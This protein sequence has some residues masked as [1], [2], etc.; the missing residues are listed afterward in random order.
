MFDVDGDLAVEVR[1]VVVIVPHAFS[2]MSPLALGVTFPLPV[3]QL[4]F[5]PTPQALA[6]MWPPVPTA[7]ASTEAVSSVFAPADSRSIVPPSEPPPVAVAWKARLVAVSVP[8]DLAVISP[9]IV[10]V[11]PSGLAC[12][13][14]APLVSPLTVMELL[15][16]RSIQELAGARMPSAEISP[17]LPPVESMVMLFP[18]TSTHAV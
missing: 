7:C 16:N 9:A 1:A 10:F 13:A 14:Y 5:E 8:F 12:T 2:E 11:V 4:R 3:S 6:T 17:L 15:A 18:Q